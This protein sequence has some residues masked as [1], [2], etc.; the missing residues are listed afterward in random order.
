MFTLGLVLENVYANVDALDDAKK[1]RVQ[2]AVN[3]ALHDISLR[4][5]WS[6]YLTRVTFETLPDGVVYFPSDLARRVHV[7]VRDTDDTWLGEAKFVDS[8]MLRQEK[9]QERYRLLAQ[10]QIP[11]SLG[12]F[13]SATQVTFTD[14]S[15]TLPSA[16]DSDFNLSLTAQGGWI[17]AEGESVPRRVVIGTGGSSSPEL[18]NVYYGPNRVD[19]N[20]IINPGRQKFSLFI[21]SS[22]DASDTDAGLKVDIT[23]TRTPEDA[24]YG[25][26]PINLPSSYCLEAMATARLLMQDRRRDDADRWRRAGQE[27]LI[28]AMDADLEFVTEHSYAPEYADGSILTL[29]KGDADADTLTQSPLS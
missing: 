28:E 29:G 25:G 12:N 16:I 3:A 9:F 27:A 11:N 6:G 15:N 5:P 19:Q 18:Y 10:G 23:Y 14:G 24:T 1:R 22:L 7:Q 21:P 26:T 8:T 4:H 20:V 2:Q 17:Q 13:R